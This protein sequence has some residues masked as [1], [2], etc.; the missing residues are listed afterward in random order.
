MKIENNQSSTCRSGTQQQPAW[1]FGSR[2]S[3]RAIAV[4]TLLALTL[5]YSPWDVL[6]LIGG[7]ID[8]AVQKPLVSIAG[9]L[10]SHVF[11]VAGVAATQHPTDSRDT[12]FDWVSIFTVL[13]VSMIAALIWSAI[14]RRRLNPGVQAT[15]LR[16]ITRLILIFVMVRYGIFKI[17]PM[18]M[19]RPSLGVLNEPVGQSSQMS[20]LWTLI[21]SSPVYQI[22]SGVFETLCAVLLLFEAT[23]LLGTLLGIVVMS[24]VLLFNFCFDIPVKLGALLILFGFPV[25][26]WQDIPALYRF[27]CKHC[28]AQ[29]HTSWRPLFGT[30]RMK[31]MMY[32]I[33]LFY[34]VCVVYA[35]VPPAYTLEMREMTHLHSPSSLTGEWHVDSASKRVGTQTEDAPVLTAELVPMTELYLEQD[36]RA[37]ARSR[38]GR[39]WRG[40][41]MI[42]KAR[43]TLSLYSYYFDGKRFQATYKY[44]L[45]DGQHLRLEPIGK[46]SASESTLTL[47]RVPLPANYPLLQSRFHWVEEWALER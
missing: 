14:D 18:Q 23:A 41:A 15:W 19:S 34:V 29:L 10:I 5:N 7:Y 44:T 12:A 38:D 46:A 39:L 6:P 28:S 8:E 17:F 25:L 35:L 16:H 11:H 24:N 33:E 40:A 27:F 45:A 22:L 37:M 31:R 2:L 3:F 42:D 26:L 32:G 47:T 30:T 4:F 21:G 1:S 36:G 13:I 43:S 9:W 20:L